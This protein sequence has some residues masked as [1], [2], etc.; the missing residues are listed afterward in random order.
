M[1]VGFAV[2]VIVP[3]FRKF[4]VSR[5]TPIHMIG[6]AIQI[7]LLLTYKILKTGTSNRYSRYIYSR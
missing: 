4:S 5:Q 2:P 1:I 7:F 3:V 6:N